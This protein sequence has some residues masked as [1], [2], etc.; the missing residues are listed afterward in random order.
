MLRKIAQNGYHECA[1]DVTPSINVTLIQAQSVDVELDIISMPMLS[2]SLYVNDSTSWNIYSSLDS[3]GVYIPT[4]IHAMDD[5]R[6]S[7]TISPNPFKSETS[8]E[9]GPE[10]QG[11]LRLFSSSGSQVIRVQLQGGRNTLKRGILGNGIY[12]FEIVTTT[13]ERHTGKLVIE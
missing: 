10:I 3:C 2:E 7:I 6:P 1:L 11:V 9:L 5:V 4:A 12:F 13:N 8:I